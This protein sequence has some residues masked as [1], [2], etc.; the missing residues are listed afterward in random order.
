MDIPDLRVVP[1]DSLLLHEHADG[2]RVARLEARLREDGYLKNPPIV[3]PIPGT[4]KYV[5]LD[6]ANRSSA[7]ANIGSPHVLVQIVEYKSERVQL[8]TWHHL[9]TGRDPATFLDEISR[10]DG[11]VLQAAP[12]DVARKALTQRAI[13]AYIVLPAPQPGVEPSVFM[14]D[15]T[16]GTD[17]HGAETSTALLNEMVNT[18]KGDP[19][20]V[21]HRV[22][23]DELDDLMSYYDN[24]S[25]LIVFPPYSP[26]D[27]LKLAQTGARVPRVRRYVPWC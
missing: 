16:P 11:L 2:K 13:L 3:A 23:T 1:T 18:Y 10:V 9:I 4:Y 21:I 7:L 15:G 14:V 19:L 12:L 8:L 20:V 26:D 22:S 17:H 27:I 6:G 24:V 5:V 25:G